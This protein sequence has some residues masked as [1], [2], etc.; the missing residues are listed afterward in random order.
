M[1][2]Y[3]ARATAALMSAALTL[4]LPG[5]AQAYVAC[6]LPIEGE[7]TENDA[8][9]IDNLETSRTRGLASALRAQ[10]M[11]DR[12]IV[13]DLFDPGTTPILAELEGDY[14]CRTIK[15][16][17]NL[18][19]VV[20]GWFECRISEEAGLFRIEKLTGSQ[21]FSGF[22]YPTDAFGFVYRGA[23]H[24]GYEQPMDYGDDPERNESGCL[25]AVTK[26]NRHFILELPAPAFESFHDVI[27][28][29]PVR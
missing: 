4:G 15:L 10:S 11:E 22:L 25:S 20:Y 24:Y 14:R 1:T 29:V 19:L 18:P 27:E 5:V 2:T 17:G 13:A 9:R 26:G 3:A 21:N 28:F 16:G 7:L 12:N 6:T 8:S 23:Y